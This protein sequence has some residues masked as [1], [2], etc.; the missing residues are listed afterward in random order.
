[1]GSVG[2]GVGE[3]FGEI[4]RRRGFENFQFAWLVTSVLNTKY[5]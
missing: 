2:Q 4:D 3:M 1:M 5:E